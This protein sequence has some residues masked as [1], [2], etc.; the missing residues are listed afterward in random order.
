MEAIKKQIKET[1]K[2]LKTRKKLEEIKKKIEEK[3]KKTEEQEKKQ[4]EDAKK[5]IKP[6]EERKKKEEEKKNQSQIQFTDKG[7]GIPTISSQ[8]KLGYKA[9][10]NFMACCVLGGLTNDDQIKKAHE[11]ALGNKYI[12]KDDFVKLNYR[13]FAKKISEQFKTTY[14]SEWD[15]GG[16][17]KKH[18]FWVVDGNGKEIFNSAGLG[19]HG[20]GN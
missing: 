12:G 20:R 7:T 16:S 19:Y 17:T 14:H 1:K 15:R 11:W 10:C 9:G 5:K 6:E 4:L 8:K 3:I 2:D 18:H 13:D